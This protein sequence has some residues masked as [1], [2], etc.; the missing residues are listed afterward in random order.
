MWNGADLEIMQDLEV[1]KVPWLLEEVA[2]CGL[3]L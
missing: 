3:P 1:Y 2:S